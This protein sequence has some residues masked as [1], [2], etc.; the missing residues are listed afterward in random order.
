MLEQKRN[1]VVSV[2]NMNNAV[3]KNQNIIRLIRIYLS[4]NPSQ[5]AIPIYVRAVISFRDGQGKVDITVG[6]KQTLGKTVSNITLKC[7]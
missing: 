7:C 3:K 5:V 1:G 6:P 2:F 4:F